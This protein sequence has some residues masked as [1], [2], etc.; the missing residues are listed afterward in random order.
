MQPGITRTILKW[1]GYL[2]IFGILV[3]AYALRYPDAFVR[4]PNER[5]P[6]LIGDW[7]LDRYGSVR[8]YTFAKDGT[9]EIRSPDRETRKFYWG[10]EGDRL[11]MKYQTYN[12]WTAP[13]YEID[14]RESTGEAS[15]KE[16]DSAYVMH[17]SR[18]APDSATL[19]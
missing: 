10:T 13:E 11:R 14:I 7:F 6:E 18:Q 19:R 16:S 8:K 2:A 9:G 1:L 4:V 3:G 15:I 12:G 17:L 5:R